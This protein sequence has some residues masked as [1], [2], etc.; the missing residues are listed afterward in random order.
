MTSKQGH[1]VF[2]AAPPTD[3]SRASLWPAG[4]DVGLESSGC[5]PIFM[6]RLHL[7]RGDIWI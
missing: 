2:S 1:N 3:F 6:M 5:N 7:L 4:V